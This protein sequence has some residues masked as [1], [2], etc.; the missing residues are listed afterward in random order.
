MK[1]F[2]ILLTSNKILVLL[3]GYWDLFA[4]EIPNTILL[5]IIKVK[6]RFQE[7]AEW[8]SLGLDSAI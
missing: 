3:T 2:T 5:L 7:Q 6:Q 4:S 8:E 1:C